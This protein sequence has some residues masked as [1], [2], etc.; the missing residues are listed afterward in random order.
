M[1]TQ[2][3]KRSIYIAGAVVVIALVAG[4]LFVGNAYAQGDGFGGGF[5]MPGGRGYGMG[6]SM[7]YGMGHGMGYGMMYGAPVTDTTSAA[8]VGGG[9][10]RHGMMGYGMM[11][12]SMMSRGMM[13]RGMGGY[14]MMGG[15]GYAA[16]FNSNATP[17]TLDQA[18]QAAKE[19]IAAYGNP[20]LTLGEILEFSNNYYVMVREQSTEHDAFE[21]LVD[22]Y[23]GAVYPEPGPN[24]MW[25]TKYGHMGGMMGSWSNV[26]PATAMTISAQKARSLAQSYLDQVAPGT[27]V[28]EQVDT[29]YGYYTLETLKDGQVSGMLSVNG[30][31]G[32]VWPHTW[33]GAF[34]AQANG[35]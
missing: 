19:A 18:T 34:V 9:W 12:Q 17:L 3:K 10:N 32:Q 23:S 33:H 24:R 1:T 21:L 35:E 22:R 30:Y 28:E 8:Y 15:R 4:L 14:G 31:T 25:N 7:G 29:F 6:Q 13:G 2:H 16:P 5:G 11:G 20:D 27:V 26:T